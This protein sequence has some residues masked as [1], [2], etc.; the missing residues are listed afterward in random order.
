MLWFYYSTWPVWV[1][2]QF[3]GPLL[4][5]QFCPLFFGN[6]LLPNQSYCEELTG[7]EMSHRCLV[8][9]RS[10]LYVYL[11]N[12]KN[13]HFFLRFGETSYLFMQNVAEF[14]QIWADLFFL[15]SKYF[16]SLTCPLF[17]HVVCKQYLKCKFH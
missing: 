10:G 12:V 11:G 1:G 7:Q 14:D 8:E 13:E 6:A 9:F 5:S 3:N 15:L 16:C 17:T 4:L 2:V